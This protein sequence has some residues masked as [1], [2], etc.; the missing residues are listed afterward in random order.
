MRSAWLRVALLAGQR[1]ETHQPVGGERVGRRGRRCR[2]GPSGGR[3]SSRRPRRWCRGH[4]GSGPRTSRASCRPCAAPRATHRASPVS[5]PSRWNAST[6]AAWS[7]ASAAWRACGSPSAC[8][9]R[10]QRPSVVP[11]LTEQELAVGDGGGLP[12]VPLEHGG[13]IGQRPQEQCVPLGEDLVV[14][15]GAPPLLAGV[16]QRPTGPLDVLGA[17]TADHDARTGSGSNARRRP[18]KLPSS[19][20]PYHAMTSST[21]SVVQPASALRT[22]SGVQVANSPSTPVARARR[23]SRRPRPSRSH[24]RDGGDRAARS[25]SSPRPPVGSS[26]V[27][28]HRVRLA[29]DAD[30]QR[31]VVEHLLEVGDEPL[32]VGRV[33]GEATADVVVHPA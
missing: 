5:S 18:R 6:S 28:E 3:P 33:A 8:H 13:R 17:A 9:D 22:S 15:P 20:M 21:W 27:A 7:A 29:V 11:Q 1:S 16:E 4:L 23:A 32:T 2:G 12:V 30:E 14:E 19:V 25:R 24:R 31:L 10:N 26:G